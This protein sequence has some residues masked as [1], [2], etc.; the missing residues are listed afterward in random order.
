MFNVSRETPARTVPGGMK[1][2]GF[3]MSIFDIIHGLIIGGI[4]TA[5]VCSI[6]ASIWRDEK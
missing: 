1:L 3:K 5:I 2:E 6:A 4:F